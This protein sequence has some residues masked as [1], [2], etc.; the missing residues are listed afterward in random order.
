MD[1]NIYS[2]RTLKIERGGNMV[3]ENRNSTDTRAIINC[4]AE[5]AKVKGITF[6]ELLHEKSTAVT[7]VVAE[8]T[9]TNQSDE[10][11]D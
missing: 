11:K 7:T 1:L 3:G 9:D 8:P 2:F 4:L 10:A 6:R 5:Q